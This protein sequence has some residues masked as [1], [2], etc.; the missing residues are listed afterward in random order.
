MVRE[1]IVKGL[2]VQIHDKTGNKE[3]YKNIRT[4]YFNDMTGKVNKHINGC[5]VYMKFNDKSG[6]KEHNV[7]QFRLILFT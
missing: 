2:M 1:K 6:K 5:V 4:F 3:T 7:A